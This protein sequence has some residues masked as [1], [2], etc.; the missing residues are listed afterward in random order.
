MTL[1]ISLCYAVFQLD[2][3]NF[4]VLCGGQFD[5]D[6]FNVLCGGQLHT[7]SLDEFSV[8]VSLTL[9]VSLYCVVNLTLSLTLCCEDHL[10]TDNL[11]V[12]WWA[13]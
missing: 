3:D 9:T 12:L 1:A 11:T 6:N 10:D 5:T 7:D 13:N 4:N 8:M 2:T